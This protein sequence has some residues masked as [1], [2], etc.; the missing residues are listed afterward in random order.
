MWLRSCTLRISP[1]TLPRRVQ[2][3][4]KT[5]I[6]LDFPPDR[7]K[8]GIFYAGT[9]E[10]RVHF[11]YTLT[12]SMDRPGYKGRSALDIHILQLSG[13]PLTPYHG[14]PNRRS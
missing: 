2:A 5:P 14:Y 12:I 13:K 3:T 4:Q 1:G 10:N 11:F 6:R 7:S 8:P 9:S